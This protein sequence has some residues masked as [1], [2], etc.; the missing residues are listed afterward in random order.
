MHTLEPGRL[1]IRLR[2]PSEMIS[3]IPVCISAET[4]EGVSNHAFRTYALTCTMK[5]PLP[6]PVPLWLTDIIQ[7][8]PLCFAVP[9]LPLV[10]MVFSSVDSKSGPP[11]AW[12][13]GVTLKVAI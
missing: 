12:L 9:E 5:L 10:G 3:L 1:M 11:E 7:Y 6:L 4:H 13:G 2:H 8:T